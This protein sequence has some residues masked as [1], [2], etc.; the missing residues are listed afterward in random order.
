MCGGELEVGPLP[1]GA[2]GRVRCGSMCADSLSCNLLHAGS[3]GGF[4]CMLCSMAPTTHLQASAALVQRCQRAPGLSW[5]RRTRLDQVLPISLSKAAADVPINVPAMTACLW[6]LSCCPLPVALHM[7][8]RHHTAGAWPRRR[9]A[10][11]ARPS[12]PPRCTATRRLALVASALAASCPSCRFPFSAASCRCAL[13]VCVL[14]GHN[15]DGRSS[16]EPLLPFAH[17]IMCDWLYQHCSAAADAPARR[18]VL[19]VLHPLI[20]ACVCVY[21]YVAR[22]ADVPDAD[23]VGGVQRR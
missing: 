1:R 18:H 15:D 17:L 6:L 11:A 20:G 22:T 14:V 12:S 9:A 7:H 8:T 10:T 2:S 19:V 21:A 13:V 4:T 23:C 3:G 5:R 16:K